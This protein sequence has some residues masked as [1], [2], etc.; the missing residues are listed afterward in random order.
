MNQTVEHEA[1]EA[2]LD[3]PILQEEE[4]F[5]PVKFSKTANVFSKIRSGS[6]DMYLSECPTWG[7][8]LLFP[9]LL[10][11]G[12][13]GPEGLYEKVTLPEF[14]CVSQ[15]PS[16]NFHRSIPFIFYCNSA[17]RRNKITGVSACKPISKSVSNAITELT[18][19][20]RGN[21]NYHNVNAL[22]VKR[23]LNQVSFHTNSTEWI[24][25]MT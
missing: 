22:S 25:R 19:L 5:N 3:A 14:R 13:G 1:A 9:T 7:W 15:I 8:E 20:S 21:H 12:K 17:T 10:P 11:D 16:L 18:K 23:L 6:G 4:C 2:M 24:C